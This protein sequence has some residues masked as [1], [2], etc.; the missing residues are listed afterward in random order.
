MSLAHVGQ[1]KNTSNAMGSWLSAINSGGLRCMT[2]IG[3]PRLTVCDF[4]NWV[5][6]G[7]ALT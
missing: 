6:T 3:S 4:D 1:E 2:E 7:M 5:L